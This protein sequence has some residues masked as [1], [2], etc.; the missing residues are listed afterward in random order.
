MTSGVVSLRT[1]GVGKKRSGGT[2]SQ[3]TILRKVVR[4]GSLPDSTRESVANGT[5][6]L[7]TVPSD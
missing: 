2:P 5:Q 6:S 7:Q 4:S 3:P 1:R